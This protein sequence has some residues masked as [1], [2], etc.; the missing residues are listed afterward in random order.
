[1]EQAETL[2]IIRTYRQPLAS[3]ARQIV[4]RT[5]F[6]R[7]NAKDEHAVPDFIREHGGEIWEFST[8]HTR[9]IHEAE[10]LSREIFED[11]WE[12]ADRNGS[13]VTSSE[14]LIIE[15]IAIRRLIKHKWQAMMR[16]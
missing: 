15:N 14:H 7:L 13:T 3:Q 16:F 9:S 12:F 6:Q 4:K 8:K 2:T 10:V 11:I 5:I 1:M